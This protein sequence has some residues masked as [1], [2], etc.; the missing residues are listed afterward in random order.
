[1]TSLVARIRI[2]WRIHQQKPLTHE[3]H[4]LRRLP[5]GKISLT[6]YEDSSLNLV[7]ESKVFVIIPYAF[8]RKST[9]ATQK[10]NL[11]QRRLDAKF[12]NSKLG[13]ACCKISLQFVSFSGVIISVSHI[14]TFTHTF[15]FSRDKKVSLC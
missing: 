4:Q 3:S 7:V 5:H 14:N 6:P 8:E 9:L 15:I 1:M 12:E 11:I 13:R 2:K 10:N